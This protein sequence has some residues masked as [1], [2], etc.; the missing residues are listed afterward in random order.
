MTIWG[1]SVGERASRVALALVLIALAS[2][3]PDVRK[4][5]IGQVVR[6]DAPPGAAPVLPAPPP[7]T[8]P[9]PLAPAP[10]VRVVLIDGVNLD[11]ALAMPAWS[12]LCA[13]GLDLRVD[14]GFPTVSLPVQ[15]ALWTGLTQQQ[16]GVLFHSGY[17]LAD[18]LGARGIPAQVARAGGSVAVAEA[19][20]YIIQS[21]GFGEAQ[22]PLGDG[23]QGPEGWDVAW[24]E[25][26]RAA[27]AGP[28]RLAFVHVLRVDTAGHKKGRGSPA[29]AEAV[30]TADELLGQLVAAG[31][32]AHPDARW[33]VLADHGHVAAGGHGGHAP[34]IRRVRACIAGPGIATG[35]GAGPI[36]L[37]DLSR[38][39]A[40]STGASLPAASRGRPLGAA[41]AAPLAGDEL[42]PGPSAGRWWVAALILLAAAGVTA[43]ALGA[44]AAL[45]AP[46]WWP[47]ALLL[48][49]VSLGAP[50]LSASFVY[51]PRGDKIADAVRLATYAAALWTAAAVHWA[52]RPAWRVVV[53]TVAIP[54]A[55]L[56]AALVLCGGLAVVW[57][58]T[59]APITARWTAWASVTWLIVVRALWAVGLA[60]LATS[61]LPAFDPWAR[62]GTRRSAP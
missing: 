7:G 2:W 48:A 27:V 32:A 15:V 37:V 4:A 24:I 21:L 43:W 10:F 30:R 51:A 31:D 22:P 53:A 60:L 20:P 11:D 61:V 41:L 1:E 28:A 8:D 39:I 47:L 14:V 49:V 25:A 56:A 35:T 52:G 29:W 38:A 36:A 23:K 12:A 9:A 57:G 34:A 55:C 62:R 58:D 46:W 33:F 59:A 18:P 44:R 17:P 54:L 3:L 40:D 26:A 45:W 5:F 13:R 6:T 50:T 42:V 16:T 19:F